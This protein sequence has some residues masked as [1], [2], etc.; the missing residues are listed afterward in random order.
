MWK[1]EN[2][3]LGYG[4]FLDRHGSK[5]REDDPVPPVPLGVA[6]QDDDEL[7]AVK[8]THQ[9]EEFHYD[10]GQ[11]SQFGGAVSTGLHVSSAF[12]FF[13]AFQYD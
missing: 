3:V 8:A 7:Y 5:I 11:K 6:Q 2:G 1:A 12:F 13:P 4:D 9:K 10:T